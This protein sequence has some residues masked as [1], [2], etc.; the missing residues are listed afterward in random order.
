MKLS[1]KLNSLLVAPLAIALFAACSTDE[2]L[3]DGGVQSQRL[4]IHATSEAGDGTR[5]DYSDADGKYTAKWN[6]EDVVTILL[7][8]RPITVNLLYL[9]LTM[10]N[11]IVQ[12]LLVSLPEH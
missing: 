8:V 11:A 10:Q 9:R 4:I 3:S 7:V 1:N 12:T 5:T 6:K 2:N